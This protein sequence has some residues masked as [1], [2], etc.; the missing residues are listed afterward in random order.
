MSP[1]DDVSD[2]TSV[3]TGSQHV[4][5][6]LGDEELCDIATSDFS[7]LVKCSLGLLHELSIYIMFLLVCTLNDGDH[8]SQV[9]LG[10]NG[11]A[12]ASVSGIIE[13]MGHSLNC[14]NDVFEVCTL[15]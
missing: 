11:G 14:V 15:E 9:V 13:G 10:F 3:D 7:V 12:T 4:L 2:V 8:F 5:F 1:E 6:L